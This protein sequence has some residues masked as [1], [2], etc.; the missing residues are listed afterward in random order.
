MNIATGVFHGQVTLDL[1]RNFLP[2]CL[3]KLGGSRMRNGD[4]IVRQEGS[5]IWT[6]KILKGALHLR[7][8]F[9]DAGE[10]LRL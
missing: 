1:V 6:T 10:L 7:D 5:Q 9:C 8:A 4:I 3:F 2:Q